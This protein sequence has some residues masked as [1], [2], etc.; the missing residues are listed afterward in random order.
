[1][2]PCSR[3]GTKTR[4]GSRKESPGNISTPGR[5]PFG[6]V[7]PRRRVRGSVTSPT[8]RSSP[9]P[10]RHGLERPF[11]PAPPTPTRRRDPACRPPKPGTDPPHNF[12]QPRPHAPTKADTATTKASSSRPRSPPR[13][14]HQPRSGGTRRRI[15]SST[16]RLPAR[17]RVSQH[18]S[19][20]R[21]T[22]E[23][24]PEYRTPSHQS[25]RGTG[26]PRPSE[27]ANPIRPQKTP[28]Q[29]R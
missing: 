15:P 17:A 21:P 10:P 11:D 25:R 20:D 4:K 28:Q 1:M 8:R 27:R 16:P 7:A 2:C 6:S 19:R 26:Y 29:H 18:K 23:E 12:N 24:L 3:M 13:P 22:K 14:L 9:H 5:V